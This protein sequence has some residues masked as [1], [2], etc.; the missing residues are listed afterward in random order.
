MQFWY[1]PK[2]EYSRPGKPIREV[3]GIVMHWTAAPRMDA[4]QVRQYFADKANGATGY[5]SAHYV[6]GQFGEAIA[7][8]P[9]SEIAYH[10][11]SETYTDDAVRL[12]GKYASSNSSPNYC[13]IGI[14]LCPVDDAGN[15]STQTITEAIKLCVDICKRYGLTAHQITTH[16]N[17][18]GWKDC[19]K[20]WTEK[21]ELLDAFI[22]SVGYKL[23]KD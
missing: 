13:S 18:V 23:K 2:N 9:E 10:C 21:P 8:V 5:G 3:L 4:K 17:V 19:P 7:V 12:F 20:L 15:F 1:I 6:I 16:H 22:Y 11:G 14:E